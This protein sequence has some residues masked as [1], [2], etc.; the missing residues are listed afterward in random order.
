MFE[1]GLTCTC[2][3]LKKP[4]KVLFP[5]TR[6]Q[7]NCIFYWWLTWNGM[8]H[9]FQ[10]KR[11]TRVKSR[12]RRYVVLELMTGT[13]PHTKKI[14]IQICEL[15]PVV[16][17]IILT[18]SSHND[19]IVTANNT[20]VGSVLLYSVLT[21]LSILSILLWLCFFQYLWRHWGLWSYRE[22]KRIWKERKGERKRERKRQEEIQEL[23]KLLW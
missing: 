6:K 10:V 20:I 14:S 13:F 15:L 7:F 8:N 21:V 22:Y 18:V 12:D 5:V 1:T 17:F 11:K 3:K 2:Q 4:W 23:L 9:G 19:I 16:R